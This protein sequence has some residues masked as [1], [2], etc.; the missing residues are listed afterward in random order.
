MKKWWGFILVGVAIG[1]GIIYFK[2]LSLIKNNSGVAEKTAV[3]NGKTQVVVDKKLVSLEK[4]VAGVVVSW[5]GAKAELGFKLNGENEVKKMTV[6][7]AKMS[8]FIPV[9]QHKTNAVLPLVNN[10][11]NWSTAFCP[12]DTLTVGYASD[13]TVKLLFNTGYR[14]CGF[15]GE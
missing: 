7:S 2:D 12:Q 1:L 5:D 3:S 4:Q 13:G 6:D 9:A 10:D 8:L 15:K 14:M 11:K